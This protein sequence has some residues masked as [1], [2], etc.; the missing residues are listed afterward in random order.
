MELFCA[1][2]RRKF[3]RG[4]K[5]A[6]PGGTKRTAEALVSFG[7]RELELWFHLLRLEA[8]DSPQEA[9]QGVRGLWDM[10]AKIRKFTQGSKRFHKQHSHKSQHCICLISEN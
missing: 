6:C 8:G 9:P 7:F 3:S 5:R 10:A 4:I 2:Q 1:R